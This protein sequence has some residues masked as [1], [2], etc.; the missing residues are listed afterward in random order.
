MNIKI[1]TRHS[2][3]N[4]GSLLQSIAA[5]KIMERL[6]HECEII[7]YKRDDERGLK[8]ILTSL[9]GKASW[10]GGIAKKIAYV[11]ARYPEEKLA[12]MKF[13]T[14][15][16]RYL[17]LTHPCHDINDL[18]KLTADVFVTGSDQVWGPTLN[19][20][21][22]E[23][24]FLSFVKDK[25]K[26]AWAASFG[27]TDF[28]DE[29]VSEYKRFLSCYDAIAV[30]EDIAVKTLYEWGIN[31]AGQVLDPTLMLTGEEWAKFIKRRRIEGDY[32]LVYQIHN[33]PEMDVYAER[34]ARHYGLPLYRVSPTLHQMRRGGKFVFLP[35]L[36]DFL[37]CLRFCKILI[38]DS[39]HGTAFAINFNRQFVE[40]LPNNSTGSRNQSILRLTGLQGRIALNH[41]DFSFLDD[42][43]DY[44]HVN[45][46][47][48]DERIKSME[49]IKEILG[50]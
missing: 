40:V 45:E 33:N 21:Y 39:F 46:I 28:T 41:D 12:E 14:M 31:C 11:L 10:N 49:I 44:K 4:Y 20:H 27:R 19:G 48:H 17:K 15:R 37:S 35:Q 34:L 36:S 2:P 3:S 38:T 24:Y 47:L 7:D 8:F 26:V 16:S 43:I 22:D 29:T 6:G 5:V 32:A 18:E 50:R 23:A 42:K 13:D 9:R 1:I 30:R 25:P